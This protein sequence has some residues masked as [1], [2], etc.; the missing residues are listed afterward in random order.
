LAAAL[1]SKKV[2]QPAELKVK[3]VKN[4]TTEHADVKAFATNFKTAFGDFNAFLKKELLANIESVNISKEEAVL[5]ADI[6][7]RMDSVPLIDKYEAYQLLND[8]WVK[9]TGDLEIIQ[10]ETFAATK[11]VDP[12]M[13]LKKKKGREEEVQ[14]GW[15]GRIMP[16]ELVQATYLKK[17]LEDLKLKENRLVEITAEY[18]EILDSL[19]E[20]EKEADTVNDAMSGFLSAEVTKAV[21]QIKADIKK[22]GNFPADAYE[23]KIL[24]VSKLFTEEKEGKKQVRLDTAKLHSL[25]KKTIEELSDAQV[26]ELLELK[27]ISPLVISLNKLP[28]VLINELTAK[29]QALADKYATTYAEVTEEIHETEK[30]LAALIDELTGS[31]YDMKGLNQFKSFLKGE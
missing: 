3:A 15:I 12:N 20:E 26:F 11:K 16:F 28:E 29:V 9:I 30:T 13:V 14:N 8:E 4:V 23:S 27:W 10:T 6:F 7:K 5:S 2:N 21:K 22:N 17:D 31:E 19:T 18:E 25:T 24:N 1:F